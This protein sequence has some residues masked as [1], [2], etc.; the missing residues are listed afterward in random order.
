MNQIKYQ[1]R[2]ALPIWFVMLICN[3][4]PDNRFSIKIRGSLVALILPGKPKK[5][6][7][8]R[9]V[10]LLGI[11]TLFIGGNVYIAKGG[12]INALGQITIG[13]NVLISPYVILASLTHSYSGNDYSGPSSSSPI[14]VGDGSWIAAHATITSGV[15]IGDA[16]LIGANSCVIHN[17]SEHSLYSGVPAKYICRK[18]PL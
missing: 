17:T 7:L 3:F 9:D 16:C 2:Y 12:W 11:D 6:R 1:L 8:G 4:L 13:N 14:K 10:T 15:S 5:F 18:G